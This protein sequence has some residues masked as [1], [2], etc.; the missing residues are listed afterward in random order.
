MSMLVRRMACLEDLIHV[1]FQELDPVQLKVMWDADGETQDSM[2]DRDH[3]CALSY[4]DLA[5]ILLMLFS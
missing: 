5:L 2:I 4:Q 1:I 3:L